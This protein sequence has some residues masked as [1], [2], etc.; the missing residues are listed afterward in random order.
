MSVALM[1]FFDRSLEGGSHLLGPIGGKEYGTPKNWR[2]P[3]VD[4]FTKPWRR[5]LSVCTWVKEG[6]VNW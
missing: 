5:P 1:M 6:G 4:G 3:G 2:T